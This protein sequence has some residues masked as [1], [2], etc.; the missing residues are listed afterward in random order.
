M[1]QN[2]PSLFAGKVD[3][4]E[5]N[6]YGS[7]KGQIRLALLEQDLR[8]FCPEFSLRSLRILDIGGGSGRFACICAQLGHEVLLIDS[9]EEMMARA[10]ER[11]VRS[12]L[13]ANVTLVH[14]DF[15]AESCSFDEQF[16]L[17]LLHGSAEWMS[18]PKAAITKACGCVRAGG[19]LSL[20]VFNND[21]LVLKRGINGM[22]IHE[23]GQ[24]SKKMTSL[25]PPGAMSPGCVAKIL[26][27]YPGKICSKSGI[28]VFYKFFRQGIPEK[29]LTPGE[30]LQQEQLYFRQEP[31]ASLGEHTHFVW[32]SKS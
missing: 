29:V 5:K 25:T 9:S 21:R 18:S 1:N 26:T 7:V 31:F 17:V 8:E 12:D 14:Q 15:L 6:V 32:Q 19:Y 2:E 4:L 3:R 22:L 24:S 10:K 20:L 28:R 11:I 27:Q 30:W 13:S 16:D 23:N